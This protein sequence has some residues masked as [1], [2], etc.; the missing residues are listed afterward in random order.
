MSSVP[1]SGPG[2]P[3]GPGGLPLSDF[4]LPQM[5]PLTMPLLPSSSAWVQAVTKMFSST[6]MGSDTE[7]M[8]KTA[9][10]LMQSMQQS[11]GNAINQESQLS[12]ARRKQDLQALLG[13]D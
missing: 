1:P 2:G 9:T 11:I 7:L 4:G 8:Q 12:R 6:A 10:Y 5:P 13:E 3:Q